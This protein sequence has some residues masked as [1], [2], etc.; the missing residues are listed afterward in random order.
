MPLNSNRSTLAT[1]IFFS[2]LGI[3]LLDTMA[4][5]VK[6]LGGV[7]PA[8][9]LAFFRNL[10]GLVPSVT[11]LFLSK[12]WHAK[13]RPILMR[14]WKLG[15]LRGMFGATA[16]FFFYTSLL[17]LEFATAS[18]LA[19]AGPLFVTALS[20]PILG[21]RVGPWR[22]VAVS[23]GFVG[24]ILV[25]KPGSDLFSHYSLLPVAAALGYATSTVIVRRI[26]KQVPSAL[27]NF[28]SGFAALIGAIFFTHFTTGFVPIE[29]TEHWLWIVAMG[30][31]GGC[32]V[33]C[34]IVG[35]RLTKPSNLAPFDYFGIIIAFAI[36]YIAFDEAPFHQLFPG[37]LFIV[38]G[39]G[40][41]IW[42]ERRAA[43]LKRA[44]PTVPE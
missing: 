43:K 6:H 17:H 8:P 41:I 31:L 38:L 7:Y 19:F 29:S 39:G 10:F 36:G 25:M 32:G 40:I 33:I 34:L 2:L 42:R 14:Q 1:A 15:F 9:E 4:A 18:T 3:L 27:V 13:G 12:E 28:Y 11:I 35:Y 5:I 24:I 37:V 26:D 21:D 44:G 20:V 23:I 22:W 16:Q 30:T